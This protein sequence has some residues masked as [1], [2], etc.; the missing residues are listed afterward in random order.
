M[1]GGLSEYRSGQ[2]CYSPIVQILDVACETWSNFEPPQLNGAR[3]AAHAAMVC[4]NSLVVF[5]GSNGYLQHELLTIPIP[6][7][8]S[9]KDRQLC[10]KQNLCTN[11][12]MCRTCNS[13]ASCI[14]TGTECI[15]NATS[16]EIKN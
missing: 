14:W 8:Y 12:G 11:Y 1:L 9:S 16:I 5:G 13:M 6:N 3:F 4:N 7:G 10:K 15:M 2:I